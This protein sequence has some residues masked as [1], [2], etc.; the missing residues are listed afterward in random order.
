MC[1]VLCVLLQSCVLLNHLLTRLRE[2]LTETTVDNDPFLAGCFKGS[3]DRPDL[4]FKVHSTA[5][6][7]TRETGASDRPGLPIDAL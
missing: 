5:H 6:P 2:S 3:A 1:F 4:A 7:F